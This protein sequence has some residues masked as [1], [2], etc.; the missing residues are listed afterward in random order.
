MDVCFTSGPKAAGHAC[1]WAA[2]NSGVKIA[3]LKTGV[4]HGETKDSG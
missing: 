2:T 4:N 1:S 3:N